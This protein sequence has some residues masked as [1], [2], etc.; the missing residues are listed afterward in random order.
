MQPDENLFFS[1]L[2]VKS[3]SWILLFCSKSQKY[4]N[5]NFKVSEKQQGKEKGKKKVY[6]F[7]NFLSMW[8]KFP[9][10]ILP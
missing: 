7:K 3:G 4:V 1:V 10:K 2:S 6:L 9:F 8:K 5:H